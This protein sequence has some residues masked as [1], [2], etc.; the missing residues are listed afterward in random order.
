M[1]D[2]TPDQKETKNQDGTVSTEETTIRPTFGILKYYTSGDSASSTLHVGEVIC[3]LVGDPGLYLYYTRAAKQ[4]TYEQDLSTEIFPIR[5]L[6]F[7]YGDASPEVATVED[8]ASIYGTTLTGLKGFD[9]EAFKDPHWEYVLGVTGSPSEYKLD[10]ST[11]IPMSLNYGIL[12]MNGNNR[13]HSGDNRIM[14]YADRQTY[15]QK[16]RG[17]FTAYTPRANAALN[18]KSTYRI[19]MNSGFLRQS[20]N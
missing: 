6:A 3:T 9:R 7:G 19:G 20:K 17:E 13:R 18:G 8:L 12:P 15:D 4:A 11:G 5:Y 2:V 16:G 1:S 10:G 14:I